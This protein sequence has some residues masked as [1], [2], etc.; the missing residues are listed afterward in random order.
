[1]NEAPIREPLSMANASPSLMTSPA[2]RLSE[3]AATGEPL[4]AP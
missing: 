3:M 4:R 2:N 1:M